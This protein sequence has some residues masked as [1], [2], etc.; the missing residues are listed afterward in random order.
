MPMGDFPESLSQA[1]LAGIML[2]G[3]LGVTMLLQMTATSEASVNET[4]RHSYYTVI[5]IHHWLVFNMFV[6]ST[7]YIHVYI[8]IYIYIYICCRPDAQRHHRCGDSH[9]DDEAGDQGDG[10][11]ARPPTAALPPAPNF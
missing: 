9:G 3:R 8:Y 7:R 10:G 4:I 6:L 1:M 2:V 5:D 11:T